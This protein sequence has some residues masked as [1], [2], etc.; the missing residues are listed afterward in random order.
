[1]RLVVTPLLPAAASFSSNQGGTLGRQ[2]HKKRVRLTHESAYREVE[3]D[4]DGLFSNREL[5]KRERGEFEDEHD[6]AGD[7]GI[8]A[9]SANSQQNVYQFTYKDLLLTAD[10]EAEGD[11]E[12]V[13]PSATTS[14][15]Q[16]LVY[17]CYGQSS[18]GK[19]FTLFGPR[20]PLPPAALYPHHHREA[21]DVSWWVNRLRR[22]CTGV[23]PQH[24]YEAFLSGDDEEV[25]ISCVEDSVAGVTDLVSLALQEETNLA[26]QQQCEGD[27]TEARRRAV[28]T[29]M[30]DAFHAACGVE[31]MPGR[32]LDE[33]QSLQAAL[34]RS[35]C[36]QDQSSPFADGNELTAADR[37]KRRKLEEEV[38]SRCLAFYKPAQYRSTGTA[39][40]WSR[41]KKLRCANGLLGWILL[42]YVLYYYRQSRPSLGNLSGSSRSHLLIRIITLSPRHR[43]HCRELLFVD[44]AGSERSQSASWWHPPTPKPSHPRAQSV[45]VA[46]R[47]SPL[48][49]RDP[50]YPAA[51]RR[52]ATPQHQ[53]GGVRVGRATT[54]GGAT[55]S[56][57]AA[58]HRETHHINTTL[59]SLRR[60][61]R[62]WSGLSSFTGGS[63][64][65]FK[66]S[67]LT[68]LLQPFFARHSSV[69]KAGGHHRS[70]K[71]VLVICC[72]SL[73]NDVNESIVSL[74]LGVDAMAVEPIPASLLPTSSS[75]MT[76]PTIP[77]LQPPASS[78]SPGLGPSPSSP[79]PSRHDGGD[80]HTATT[81]G[82]RDQA[83]AAVD[84]MKEV[85]YYKT[86]VRALH[87]QCQAVTRQY[88]ESVDDLA[89]VTALLEEKE[90]RNQFLEAQVRRLL[91]VVSGGG[92]DTP[93][94]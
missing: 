58:V 59:L 49:R 82:G 88:Q 63:H 16:S 20:E 4:C 22:S 27:E 68:G 91:S 18:T 87:A 54:P 44:L 65:P 75:L 50:S 48:L 15:P 72:S 23:V 84:H 40:L 78:S 47:A 19:T 77:I 83:E 56:S 45:H 13:A 38:Q 5:T 94:S 70:M 55:S 34:Q 66:E 6:E 14:P 73:A 71:A 31:G 61:I 17:M 67:T 12:E 60:V 26:Q 7:A 89:Q 21:G 93:V 62:S 9:S 80:E 79:L 39:G 2:P 30:E 43:H 3:F 53:Q 85:E 8:D 36:P 41:L 1:M 28:L 64:L 74:Q 35:R 81:A 46:R 76:A 51:A 11:T 10:E 25:I 32:E 86:L 57:T 92:A 69:S 90:A 29:L 24:L 33:L 52:A 37:K 42:E